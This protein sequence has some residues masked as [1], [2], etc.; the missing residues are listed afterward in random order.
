MCRSKLA[1]TQVS[2]IQS[3]PS[4]ND[5]RKAN[6]SSGTQHS[7]RPGPLP[8]Q[9]DLFQRQFKR[10]P[11]DD[12]ANFF[13]SSRTRN[14]SPKMSSPRENGRGSIDR[15]DFTRTLMESRDRSKTPVR[16]K[17][18]RSS[19]FSSNQADRQSKGKQYED[20]PHHPKE[21]GPRKESKEREL[22]DAPENAATCLPSYKSREGANKLTEIFRHIAQLSNQAVQNTVKHADDERHLQSINQ[23]SATLSK[24]SADAATAVAM[25]LADTIINHVR[26]KER[27]ESDFEALEGAWQN[28]FDAFIA[29]VTTV[30]DRGVESA[31]IRIREQ[32]RTMATSYDTE[33]AQSL[34]RKAI[35]ITSEDDEERRSKDGRQRSFALESE[36]GTM[37]Y[38]RGRSR[39]RD[40]KRRK[41][42]TAPASPARRDE[43]VIPRAV[44]ASFDDILHEIKG[45][46]DQQSSTLHSLQ[47][48]NHAL[49]R[50]LHRERST[51]MRMNYS[52]A[53]RTRAVPMKGNSSNTTPLRSA[54]PSTQSGPFQS[55]EKRDLV[56]TLDEQA[57]PSPP[58]RR[59]PRHSNV[60][61]K[62]EDLSV[63]DEEPENDTSGDV[64]RQGTPDNEGLVQDEPSSVLASRIMRAHDNPSPPPQSPEDT[65]LPLGQTSHTRNSPS[66]ESPPIESLGEDMEDSI[67]VQAFSSRANSKP[68]ILALGEESADEHLDAPELIPNP[69]NTQTKPS[70]STMDPIDS[71]EMAL[72][73]ASPPALIPEPEAQTDSDQTSVEERDVANSLQIEI[74]TPMDANSPT[75]GMSTMVESSLNLVDAPADLVPDTDVDMTV[76][77]PEREP[78]AQEE[79]QASTP[80]RRSS[81][82]RRSVAMYPSPLTE[83]AARSESPRRSSPVRRKPRKSGRQ[84]LVQSENPFEDGA[85]GPSQ[86]AI[87]ALVEEPEQSAKRKPRRSGHQKLDSLSPHSVK[88][89]GSLMPTTE[90]QE[91]PMTATET[92]QEADVDSPTPGPSSQPVPPPPIRFPSPKRISRPNSPNKYRLQVTDGPGTP[93]QRILISEAVSRGQLSAQEGAELISQPVAGSSRAPILKIPSTDTPARRV[94]ISRPAFP[95]SPSKSSTVRPG[96]LGSPM[97]VLFP[98]RSKSVEPQPSVPPV[99]LK[100]RSGSVEPVSD[101]SRIHKLPFPLLPATAAIGSIPEESEN[102]VNQITQATSES[103]PDKHLPIAKSHLKQPTSRIPRR[104]AKPYSKPVS[105]ATGAND[106]KLK[107]KTPIRLLK[108]DPPPTPS[109]PAGSKSVQARVASNSVSTVKTDAP[110][111]STSLKRK[112]SAFEQPSTSTTKTTTSVVSNLRKVP[113]PTKPVS[114]PSKPFSSLN[115]G[116]SPVKNQALANLRLVPEKKLQEKEKEKEKEEEKGKEKENPIQLVDPLPSS[117]TVVEQEQQE[118]VEDKDAAQAPNNEDAPS[119]IDVP[120]IVV[121]SPPQPEPKGDLPQISVANSDM[122]PE[123]EPSEPAPPVE[124]SEA[125]GLRRTSR[126]RKPVA[127]LSSGST[128][129]ANTQPAQP[130]RRKPQVPQYLGTGPF[131]LMSA[132]DLKQLTSTNTTRNQRYLAATLETEIVRK[133][134]PRPESP[135]IK[136][137]TISQKE[138]E[139]KESERKAR[140]ERRA[141]RSKKKLGE[142]VGDDTNSDEDDDDDDELLNG[143]PSAGRHTRGAG[144]DEDYETPRRI[145]RLRLGDPEND[146]EDGGDL[147]NDKKRVQWDRG[148]FTEVY[149]DEVQPRPRQVLVTTVK[150]CLAPTAKAIQLD[151]LGNLSNSESPLKNLAQESVVVKRFVYDSD[152][153]EE[154]APPATPPIKNTRSKKNKS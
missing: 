37:R 36:S 123:P 12:D 135:G 121:S 33:S 119:Q 35:K 107:A 56:V 7:T 114:S 136:A 142:G 76:P 146:S 105:T 45:R 20:A 62:N 99:R 147:S 149:L 19:E 109:L 90:D 79:T 22:H 14:G 98:E 70:A 154:P 115:L 1:R 46:L 117:S 122:I 58:L 25:P 112:R 43:D 74:D 47:E 15:R 23:M 53:T 97:R 18:A 144:E 133:D 2:S 141:K 50:Q 127:G 111:S 80:L 10:E 65:F 91:E 31:L 67:S 113:S 152:V 77:A 93:A 29:E 30:I 134:G 85:A 59:S 94:A 139:E 68:K 57:V 44:R 124:E 126:I 51:P 138:Q 21:G 87:E 38:R 63:E 41:M 52:D 8:P 64:T 40:V 17:A 92:V 60:A 73:S 116:R 26:S 100:P 27:V 69:D 16:P 106:L 54:D 129:R 48:E 110:G 84:T 89:L 125:Y 66:P 82:P 75:D 72:S 108:S 96:A 78:L 131:A 42:D 6:K 150:G 118:K 132:V 101:A 9:T 153:P 61:P 143:S 86:Q 4:T 130:R 49:K 103:S 28:M 32:V 13:A 137:K 39:S 11:D 34:K 128:S 88:L 71:E 24:I 3:K 148:L 102:D 151:G 5:H 95:S 104:T 55:P 81:R 145:K 120:S 140:A 83:V